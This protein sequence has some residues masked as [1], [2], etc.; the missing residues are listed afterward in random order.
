MKL[1]A[2]EIQ[3]EIGKYVRGYVE[4]EMQGEDRALVRV[5]EKDI[6]GLHRQGG[7]DH[8]ADRAGPGPAH[9]RA[10]AGRR[11]KGRQQE[12]TPTTAPSKKGEGIPVR[13]D[14]TKRHVVLNLGDRYTG[15]TVE[16]LAGGKYLFT[17]TPGK[18][19]QIK[20]PKGST[21]VDRLLKA[22]AEGEEITAKLV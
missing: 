19:G 1:A 13:M 18:G 14:E 16:I 15:E 3:K 21:L 12:P 4:V 11:E 20:V 10:A 2:K 5:K 9:R 6:A 22:E 7:E 8:R 17:A